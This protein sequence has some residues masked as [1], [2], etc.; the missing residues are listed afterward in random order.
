V[1]VL[2]RAPASLSCDSFTPF[3]NAHRGS[4]FANCEEVG[5]GQKK[6]RPDH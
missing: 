3:A 2:N 4:W 6:C 1:K 5:V